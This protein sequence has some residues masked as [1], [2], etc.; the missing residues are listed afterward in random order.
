MTAARH[1]L[2]L[3][4][5]PL[6][7]RLAARGVWLAPGPGGRLRVSAPPGALDPQD[8]AELARLRD[9]LLL[10]V[11]GSFEAP[12]NG[13]TT[14][15]WGTRGTLPAGPCFACGGRRFRTPGWGYW[16]CAT[17]SPCDL[18]KPR[19][20]PPQPERPGLAGLVGSRRCALGC[21]RVAEPKQYVCPTCRVPSTPAPPPPPPEPWTPTPEGQ[22]VDCRVALPPATSTAAGPASSGPEETCDE[23]TCPTRLSLPA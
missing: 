16:L 23:Q 11:L 15:A 17:C 14:P 3:D 12:P 13:P 9:A 21:G 5:S 19:R 2:P 1:P 6:L 7:A 8:R 22:C 10:L 4:P 20:S 18:P